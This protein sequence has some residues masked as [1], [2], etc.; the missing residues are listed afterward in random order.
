MK[1][2]VVLSDSH[3]FL[4]QDEEFLRVLDESDYIIHLGDGIKEINYLKEK[5][6]QKF[7]YVYGNCDSFGQDAFK[8]IDIEG[9]KVLITHGHKFS[10]KNDLFELAFECEYQKVQYGLYGHTHRAQIDE[11]QNNIT[12]I[13]PGSIKY[14]NS[15][16]YFIVAN[17]KATYKIVQR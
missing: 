1:T 12:L 3:G 11:L 9:V 14:E 7:I 10:V 17:K 13:N 5:Y 8:I 16:C 6:K 4:P 2:C 15:Y